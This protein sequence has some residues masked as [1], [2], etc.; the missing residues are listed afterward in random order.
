MGECLS[1]ENQSSHGRAASLS[2]RDP[3]LGLVIRNGGTNLTADD[4]KYNK[5]RNKNGIK[6]ADALHIYNEPNA[7]TYSDMVNNTKN[8]NKLMKIDHKNNLKVMKLLLLSARS[9]T[10]FH[11]IASIKY[12]HGS[13]FEESEF[14][15]I[16]VVIM[17]MILVLDIFTL[18]KKSQE[19]YDENKQQNMDSLDYFITLKYLGK[20]FE[21]DCRIT[22]NKLLLLGK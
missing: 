21:E 4:L 20:T 18:L 6:Y 15:E 8:I 2:K 17:S 7:R 10:K 9:S 12:V 19:S 16:N 5:N 3:E 22:R 14:V 11:T 13:C 1:A